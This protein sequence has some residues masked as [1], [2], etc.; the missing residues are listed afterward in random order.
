[1]AIQDKFNKS[2]VIYKIT[3][4]I[5]LN[6]GTLTIPAG[7]TLDFQGGSF[8]NGTLVLN[9]TA[10]LNLNGFNI[11]LTVQGTMSNIKG[12]SPE[13]FGYSPSLSSENSIKVFDAYTSYVNTTEGC[14]FEIERKGYYYYLYKPLVFQ[15]DVI[16]IGRPRFVWAG[17]Q[18]VVA[19]EGYTL[20]NNQ[21]WLDQK[22]VICIVPRS[23]TSEID[24]LTIKNIEIYCSD[25]TINNPRQDIGFYFPMGNNFLLDN[26]AVYQSNDSGFR[27]VENWM[28]EM[29]RL[30]SFYG[31]DVGIAFGRRGYGGTFTSLNV[32]NLYAQECKYGIGINGAMYST[33][34]DLACDQ[35]KNPDGGNYDGVYSIGSCW[36]TSFNNLG[37]EGCTSPNL[38]TVGDSTVTIDGIFSKDCKVSFAFAYIFNAT[39]LQ[40]SSIHLYQN[41][42]G[43]IAEANTPYYIR[44]EGKEDAT[45]NMSISID[46]HNSTMLFDDYTGGISIKPESTGQYVRVNTDD[47]KYI[48]KDNVY[49]YPTE[50]INPIEFGTSTAFPTANEVNTKLSALQSS[51]SVFLGRVSGNDNLGMYIGSAFGNVSSKGIMIY[52]TTKT[53]KVTLVQAGANQIISETPLQLQYASLSRPSDVTAGFIMFDINLKKMI[54]WDGTAWVNLDGTPLA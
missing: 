21:P 42:I 36:G 47:V 17:A 32:H 51:Q 50:F 34:S 16:G 26:I 48:F 24:R 39:V 18:P 52:N 22:A 44:I 23:Y 53:E 46:T 12:I 1:M 41:K 29:S 2:N 31:N 11:S 15:K 7:C 37:V 38:F 6:G 43:K 27:F 40:L 9:N 3:K 4:D 13:M 35:I 20:P 14:Y 10:I 19:G 54:L 49:T 25:N 5:D 30:F 33:F 45:H 8:T 28:G